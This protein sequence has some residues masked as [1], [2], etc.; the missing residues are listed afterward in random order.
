MRDDADSHSLQ[1]LLAADES[2]LSE[3]LIEQLE[4]EGWQVSRQRQ[5]V[6][7][8]LPDGRRMIMPVEQVDV[9]RP[10]VVQF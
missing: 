9:Q 10:Q 5:L 7:V 4:L 2:A 6:P 8:S 3:A 1:E